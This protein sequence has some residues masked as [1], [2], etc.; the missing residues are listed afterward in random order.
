MKKRIT[1]TISLAILFA[2]FAIILGTNGSVSAVEPKAGT[3]GDCAYEMDED[4]NL[5][6]RPI[7]GTECTL[8]SMGENY[9]SAPWNSFRLSIKTVDFEETVKTGESARG[10]FFGLLNATSIDLTGLDTSGTTNMQGMF[11]SCQSVTELDV[12]MLDTS[13]VTNMR[14]MFF[15]ENKLENLDLSNFDTSNVTDMYEMFYNNNSLTNLDLTSFDTSNV[16]NMHGMFWGLDNLESV[17]LSSFDTSKVVDFGRFMAES[18]LNNKNIPYLDVSNISTASAE[19]MVVMFGNG[20]FTVEQIKIGDDLRLKPKDGN[21]TSFGRGMYQNVETGEIFSAVQLSEGG[22]AGTYKKISDVSDEFTADY[23]VDF[24]IDKP[25]RISSFST[26]REDVF[27]MV[28][29]KVVLAKNP[30]TNTDRYDVPGEFSVIYDDIVQDADGKKYDFK[31]T[32]SNIMLLD[33]TVSDEVEEV[34]NIITGVWDGGIGLYGQTYKSIEDYANNGSSIAVNVGDDSKSYDI[35]TSVIDN[36]GN[37]VEGSYIFSIDDLDGAS[38]RDGD[39]EY[40]D[41]LNP[42]RGYGLF[43]E[44]VYVKSGFDMDTLLMS[45]YSNLIIINGNRITGK[46]VD[47]YSER[48]EFMIKANAANNRFT[49]TTGAGMNSTLFTHYQP[50]VIE[51]INLDEMDRGVLPGARLELYRGDTLV[52]AWNSEEVARKMWVMPGMYTLKAVSAPDG[53]EVVTDEIVFFVDA[54]KGIVIDDQVVERVEAL[55]RIP[56]KQPDDGK[57]DGDKG[58]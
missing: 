28:N 9:T 41:L 19:N 51:I 23:S 53:Y 52:E 31:M 45:N 7:E 8:A 18:F 43:S 30:L 17:D 39:S 27:V 34:A 6:V 10:L 37:P 26:T 21:G 3:S 55:D 42:N 20:N 5:V 58:W 24:R 47:N 25:T 12:S 46:S 4:G 1:S 38:Y 35:V 33:R 15:S 11:R 48:S 32:F 56:E 40:I 13:N 50:E 22:M 49:W 54:E 57:E 16:T 44:G 2:F 29:N 14:E 36:E